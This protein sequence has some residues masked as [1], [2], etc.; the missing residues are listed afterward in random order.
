MMFCSALMRCSIQSR[1]GRHC[2]DKLDHLDMMD[3]WCQEEMGNIVN[4][5]KPKPVSLSWRYWPDFLLNVGLQHHRKCLCGNQE[6]GQGIF[7][8]ARIHQ[9]VQWAKLNMSSQVRF[10]MDSPHLEVTPTVVSWMQLQ[11]SWVVLE[12][13][14]ANTFPCDL[15][16]WWKLESSRTMTQTIIVKAA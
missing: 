8:G 16:F 11:W 12:W 2:K 7:Q 6:K 1:L 5:W 4:L 9:R 14:M 10:G 3:W 15:V 13:R